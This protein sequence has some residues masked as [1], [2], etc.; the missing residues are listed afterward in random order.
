MN[1]NELR[2]GNYFKWISTGEIDKAIFISDRGNE[3][4]SV[5]DVNIS[6]AIGITLTEDIFRKLDDSEWSFVGFGTRLIVQH[7]KFRAIKIEFGH[8][9]FAFYFNDEL[10]NLKKYLHEAQN[11]YF[12][13]TQQELNIQL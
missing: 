10:I 13:L 8:D 7:I 11:I 2:I 5:N 1:A 3:F 4:S 9:E 6:D 12:A